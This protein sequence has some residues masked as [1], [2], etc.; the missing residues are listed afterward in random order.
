MISCACRH[1]CPERK[2]THQHADRNLFD[3]IRFDSCS[4]VQCS[5]VSV[6]PSSVWYAFPPAILSLLA[7]FCIARLNQCDCFLS[8]DSRNSSRSTSHLVFCARLLISALFLR[9]FFIIFS[10]SL[11]PSSLFSSFYHCFLHF[12]IA[13]FHHCFLHHRSLH[14]CFIEKVLQTRGVKRAE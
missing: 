2:L 3:S 13:S 14:H 12:I 5:A 11:L 6:H 9:A 1:R 10:S 7:P 8:V 4:A